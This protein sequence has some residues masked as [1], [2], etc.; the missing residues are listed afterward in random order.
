VPRYFDADRLHDV[1]ARVREVVL[2][3][4]GR[5]GDVIVHF[6]PCRPHQCPTCAMPA[7]PVRSAPLRARAPITI[8]R[9]LRRGERTPALEAAR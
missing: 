5:A 1:S 2:Q 9:A 8:E 7:C 3:A 6:D 4:S